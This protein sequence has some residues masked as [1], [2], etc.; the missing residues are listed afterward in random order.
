MHRIVKDYV[1]AQRQRRREVFV[2]LRHVPGHAQAGFGE[3]LAVIGEG[4]RK[5]VSTSSR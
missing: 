2:P 4:E 3:A 1:L 5:V